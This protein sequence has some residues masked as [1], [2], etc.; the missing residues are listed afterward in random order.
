VTGRRVST[1]APHDP[2]AVK[3]WAVIAAVLFALALLSV[4][5][6]V[7]LLLVDWGITFRVVIAA[8]CGLVTGMLAFV[9]SA[10]YMQAMDGT[11]DEVAE[12][13]ELRALDPW[14]ES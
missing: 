14:G 12:L 11:P 2:M 10:F 1:T 5:A 3:A 8:L 13:V 9:A 7:G 4:G 6:V